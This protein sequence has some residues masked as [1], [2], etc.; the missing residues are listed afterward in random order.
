MTVCVE[1]ERILNEREFPD[2]AVQAAA[3]RCRLPKSVPSACGAVILRPLKRHRAMGMKKFLL[4]ACLALAASAC[5][6]DEES[7]A[8]LEQAASHAKEAAKAAGEVVSAKTAEVGEKWSEMNANRIEAPP[9]EET[10]LPRQD[11]DVGELKARFK[12]AKDAFMEDPQKAEE[13]S[14]ETRKEG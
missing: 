6:L 1:V 2:R 14:G 4:I 7:K 8:K 3:A 11:A 9:N 13:K 12:A 10:D 5:S